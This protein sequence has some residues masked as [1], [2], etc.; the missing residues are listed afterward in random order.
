[1]GEAPSVPR[2]IFVDAN[3]FFAPRMRDIFMHLHEAEVLSIHWTKEV[4]AEWTRNVVT[5]HGAD[6]T[7]IR[8]CVYGMRDAAE[9]WEVSGYAKHVDRF[10]AVNF[11][12]R[13]VAA[14]AYKLSLDDWPDQSVALVTKNIKDFPQE[15]FKGT[16]V[17]VCSMSEY[18]DL[19]VTTEPELVI[20]T[21]DRCRRKLK[22][23]KLSHEEYVAVLMGNGCAGLA[24]ALALRWNVECPKVAKDGTFY[25][26]SEDL[27]RRTGT[28]SKHPSGKT[29]FPQVGRRIW[30]QLGARVERAY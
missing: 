26:S 20:R 17:T 30:T 25:Y 4:E 23:P 8:A 27:P 3:V 15:A 29:Y 1:M 24:N 12:D 28:K 6:Q 11:K 18:L 10:A 5:K 9:D 7:L 16:Q 21:V 13:H 2:I 19:L 14:A 22:A